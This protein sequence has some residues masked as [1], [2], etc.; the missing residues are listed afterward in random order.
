MYLRV[1]FTYICALAKCIN[2]C[3]VHYKDKVLPFNGDADIYKYT[4]TNDQ[5][6]NK[7]FTSPSLA[8][9]ALLDIFYVLHHFKKYS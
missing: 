5:A 9:T 8:V 4:P 3:T 7:M 6:V 1:S 2:I